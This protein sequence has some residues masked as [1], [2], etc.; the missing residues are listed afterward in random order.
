MNG[1]NEMSTHLHSISI[2]G[3]V[4]DWRPFNQSNGIEMELNGRF[5]VSAPAV[6]MQ[7]S[8]QVPW[9]ENSRQNGKQFFSP[10]SSFLERMR[11]VC[12]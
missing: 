9:Q 11:I 7:I 2:P 12:K 3:I 4:V 8:A 6:G 5:K 10:S 1:A